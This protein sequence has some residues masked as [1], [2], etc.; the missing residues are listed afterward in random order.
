M[1]KVVAIFLVGF[2]LGA[3]HAVFAAKVTAVPATVAKKYNI[4]TKWYKQYT[5]AKGI[6]VIASANVNRRALLK[7]GALI[8]KVL[9]GKKLN[10]A[11]HLRTYRAKNGIVDK[12][13]NMSDMPENKG[14]GK[15]NT[16]AGLACCGRYEWD[17][18]TETWKGWKRAVRRWSM[19]RF[20]FVATKPVSGIEILG[21]NDLGNMCGLARF[22]L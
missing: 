17:D 14:R 1:R 3:P 2:L 21:Y 6:P 18:K 9:Q 19:V 11:K 7:T 20:E 4:D 5:T 10:I 13:K 12:G 16:A 15:F 8:N 22:C